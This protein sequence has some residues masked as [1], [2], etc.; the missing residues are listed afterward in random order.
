[1]ISKKPPNPVGTE[2]ENQGG[3]DLVVVQSSKINLCNQWCIKLFAKSGL[4]LEDLTW[5]YLVKPSLFATI[6]LPHR[7]FS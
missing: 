7:E 2:E 5:L 6:F 3:K 4:H 1:M